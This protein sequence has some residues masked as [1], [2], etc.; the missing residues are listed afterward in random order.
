MRKNTIEKVDNDLNKTINNCLIHKTTYPHV[1]VELSKLEVVRNKKN[2]IH[3]SGLYSSKETKNL[4]YSEVVYGDNIRAKENTSILSSREIC[5]ARCKRRFVMVTASKLECEKHCNELM[6]SSSCGNNDRSGIVVL[7]T[8]IYDPIPLGNRKWS[9]DDFIKLKKCKPNILQ[10]SNHHKSSGYYSS[11][12][13]KGSF[14]KVVTSSVGQYS[15]KK[16]RNVIKQDQIEKN[17]HD[18][19][20]YTANEIERVIKDLTRVLPFIK[21]VISPVLESANHLQ[22]TIGNVNLK[23]VPSSKYG[24]WQTSI[25]VNAQTQEYHNESDCT[26]TIITIPKQRKNQSVSF[27]FLF[28]LSDKQYIN[29]PLTEGVSFIFSGMFLTHRQNKY[30]IDDSIRGD[31]F[32]IASYG[33]KRL[34]SHLRKSFKKLN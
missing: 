33:N 28:M 4:L 32:N 22:S 14:D 20:R 3:L 2:M 19:E 6:T 16:N 29:I 34:F 27:D 11:F 21:K 1:L 31:F 24:C 13:N 8:V 30:T 25:C 12:G 18:F 5:L 15:T 9:D 17:A 26:Y 7:M 23:Q 10:S